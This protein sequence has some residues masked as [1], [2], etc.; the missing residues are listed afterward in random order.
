[1]DR[2]EA[3]HLAQHLTLWSKGNQRAPHEPL[4]VLY[5]LGCWS[6]GVT[7]IPYFDV[8]KD[9]IRLLREFGPPRRTPHP[10]QP[11]WRLQGD[12]LWVVTGIGACSTNGSDRIPSC[13]N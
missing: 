2:V 4:L 13:R 10:E 1:M 5:A 11:F 6:R 12:G 9:L 7:E 3:L 8:E